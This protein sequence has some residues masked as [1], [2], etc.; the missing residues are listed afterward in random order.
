M[1]AYYARDV[2]I[3]YC[4]FLEIAIHAIYRSYLHNHE[5]CIANSDHRE[6]LKFTAWEQ[7]KFTSWRTCLCVDNIIIG[8]LYKRFVQ[9]EIDRHLILFSI[10]FIRKNGKTLCFRS[11]VLDDDHYC[12]LLTQRRFQRTC[13]SRI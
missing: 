2:F 3:R 5:S 9:F 10:R 12:L 6:F 13:R 1:T 11:I 8:R 7:E 4:D